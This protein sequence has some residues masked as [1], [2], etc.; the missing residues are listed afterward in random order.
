MTR[1]QLGSLVQMGNLASETKGSLLQEV[2]F[3]LIY[4]GSR[5]ARLV[6]MNL[7]ASP[8]EQQA[9]RSRDRLLKKAEGEISREIWEA[10]I[11]PDSLLDSYLTCLSLSVP[12]LSSFSLEM[13]FL[14]NTSFFSSFSPLE[15]F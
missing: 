13:L 14:L 6:P 4:E 11:Q 7:H 9:Q 12:L 1:E 5:E 3:V 10:K 15:S 2:P 8:R